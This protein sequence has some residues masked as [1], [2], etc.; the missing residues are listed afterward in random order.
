LVGADQVKRSTILGCFLLLTAC[1]GAQSAL[2]PAAEQ[3]KSLIGLFGLMLAVC[4][5]MYAL[6][7]GFL[8]LS[9]WRSRG[10]AAA[11]QPSAI[12][13]ADRGLSRALI[14][15]S[16]LILGALTVLITASFLLDRHLAAERARESLQ[17]RVTAQQWWWRLQYRDPAT[18]AWIETANELHLPLGKTVRVELGSNDVI[19]SFWIPNIAGKMDVIPGRLNTID[20][21]PDRTG[22]FR[23]QC[24]E[25]CGVQH[26]HMAFDVK[27]E[28]Q[29]DFDAWLAGQARPAAAPVDAAGSRGLQVVAAKCA[30]CHTIR[31]TPAAGRA[32]PDLTHVGGRQRIAAGTL[33]LNRGNLQGWVSQP[34]AVKPGTSMPATSL[35]PSDADAV[36]RYLEGLK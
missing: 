21:T 22:W 30:A 2:D 34:Q 24:A 5:V 35:D 27:V 26:A 33:A 17:V 16:A 7:I 23:G 3:S 28:S 13:P 29:A 36:S 25:F 1:S 19:H 20:L 8:A 9:V 14:I 12:A 4:A 31:G 15:W 18:G 32:G 10:R 6:V 11:D